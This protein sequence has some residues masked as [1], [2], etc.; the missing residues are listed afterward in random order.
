MFSLGTGLALLAGQTGTPQPAPARRAVNP[1]SFGKGGHDHHEY[2]RYSVDSHVVG[3]RSGHDDPRPGLFLRRPGAEEER[4]VHFNAVLH[5]RLRHQ[6]AVGPVRLFARL[7]ARYGVRNHR[8]PEVGRPP[9][10]RRAAERRLRGDPSAP[11][12]HD[13]SGDVRDHHP[14]AHHR[15]VRGA[16]EILGLSGLHPPVVDPGLRSARPLGLGDGRLA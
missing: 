10:R 4:P 14:G 3:P 7:R 9:F 15:R 12:L 11:G 13:L 2:G 1:K 6:P 5:H 16:D 8:Q